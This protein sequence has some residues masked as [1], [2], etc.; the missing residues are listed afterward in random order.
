MLP[1]P[2]WGNMW[3]GVS[4]G[5][6]KSEQGKNQVRAP[7]TW[8]KIYSKQRVDR[9]LT[10]NYGNGVIGD[11]DQRCGG[12]KT[13]RVQKV[14]YENEFQ[15]GGLIKPT[16]NVHEEGCGEKNVT[17]PAKAFSDKKS[18]VAGHEGSYV[19]LLRIK[20]IAPPK[21][22]GKS[23]YFRIYRT[24]NSAE[25]RIGFVGLYSASKPSRALLENNNSNFL[26]FKNS[27]D[28]AVALMVQGAAD[29]IRYKFATPCSYNTKN[30]RL[31]N[32]SDDDRW[33][34]SPPWEGSVKTASMTISGTTFNNMPK[35]VKDNGGTYPWNLPAIKGGRMVSGGSPPITAFQWSGEGG[36]G[37]S[38]VRVQEDKKYLVQF[39]KMNTDENG[40]NAGRNTLVVWYPFDSGDYDFSCPTE[41][42][43]KNSLSTSVDY[44][45]VV[46]NPVSAPTDPKPD[47]DGKPYYIGMNCDIYNGEGNKN[48][49][50]D[51][52]DYYQANRDRAV[53]AF[54]VPRFS[55][56]IANVSPTS[57]QDLRHVATP[58][59][60]GCN[61]GNN[62]PTSYCARI[63]YR[64]KD[65]SK[66][67]SGWYWRFT[68]DFCPTSGEPEASQNVTNRGYSEGIAK[69]SSNLI[70]YWGTWDWPQGK[71]P[72]T[73]A[74]VDSNTPPELN[75]MLRNPERG[76]EYCERLV[77]KRR[78]SYN[79]D[80]HES[81][82]KCVKLSD[83]TVTDPYWNVKPMVDVKDMVQQG[84]SVKPKGSVLLP[85]KDTDY[86]DDE[87]INE[88]DAVGKN[89]TPIT[90]ASYQLS[91]FKLPADKNLDDIDTELTGLNTNS[92]NGCDW[93]NSQTSGISVG[94]SANSQGPA[95]TSALPIQPKNEPTQLPAFGGAT[96]DATGSLAIGEKL[97]YVMSFSRPQA[98]HPGDGDANMTWRHSRASCA[99]VV[100]Y[101]KVQFQNGDIKVGR[102]FEGHDMEGNVTT[103]ASAC[104]PSNDS[105]KA[106]ILTAGS[107]SST[108]NKWGSWVE[109]GAFATGDII[110]FGSA[111]TPVG[112][113]SFKRLT[114]ANTNTNPYISGGSFSFSSCIPDYFNWVSESS[115]E[116]ENPSAPNNEIQ[117]NSLSSKQYFTKGKDID[118]I[119]NNLGTDKS[120]ILHAK[121]DNAGNGGN[122]D[123]KGNLRF[124]AGLPYSS[125][126]SLPQII[127]IADGDITID[128]SVQQ[129]DAWLIAKGKINT[130][131]KDEPTANECNVRLD[132][133]GPIA[134]TKLNLY[135]TRGAD[136]TGAT[137]GAEPAELFNLNPVH[138]LKRYAPRDNDPNANA[139]ILSEKDLPP[140]Y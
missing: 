25:M 113:S 131:T 108:D 30:M 59:D 46:F 76:D 67:T 23:S 54:H 86:N 99:T 47:V 66:G 68:C 112:M 83:V 140:R 1:E 118:L 44:K 16:P 35:W 2:S 64:V 38:W 123:I 110:S 40:N 15:T 127:I 93:I 71:I 70:D 57:E 128:D 120:I 31:L 77:S 29:T 26:N 92:M 107:T 72:A 121:K 88:D 28:L 95:A 138:I 115:A 27:G 139:P 98:G 11:F 80:R 4:A 10:I 60:N 65:V 22:N 124:F 8:I 125:L 42:G 43:W 24:N 133:N 129:V 21:E 18:K 84:E 9:T 55:H 116:Q 14:N 109:Y 53:D 132:I 106:G 137:G 117:L 7:A 135:R 103:D 91:R 104:F 102:G 17:I 41:D 122:I 6:E 94:C 89:Y 81:G 79:P 32:W 136:L 69:N 13:L 3:L 75:E 33:S 51:W 52:N 82:E 119:D 74:M 62:N 105:Q 20:T 45:E 96:S 48:K 78:S 12:D 134:A 63:Q 39:N 100:K 56:R 61:N 73:K 101:P 36:W 126:D 5:I 34:T 97:C 130:C 58:K 37:Q 19:A 49:C 87:D 111:A 85:V 114:F 90:S 50:E